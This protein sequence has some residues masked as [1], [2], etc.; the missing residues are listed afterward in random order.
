MLVQF[1]RTSTYTFFSGNVSLEIFSIAAMT[2]VAT[3]LFMCA[4]SKL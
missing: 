3:S 4:S 2:T 1:P